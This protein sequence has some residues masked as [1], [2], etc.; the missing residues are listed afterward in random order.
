M[1]KILYLAAVA[2]T[3]ATSACSGKAE[4][5]ESAAVATADTVAAEEEMIA[6]APATLDLS[7][8]K[9]DTTGYTR[10]DSGLL[11]KEVKA[12]KGEKPGAT[13][14]VTVHYTGKHLDGT[15]FDSSVERGE[16]T[17]FPLNRVIPGWTEGVQLMPVGSKYQFIIPSDL[18]YGPQG[19]PGGPIAP[20]EPL[21]FEVELISI[22][23]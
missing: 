19:T 13:D 23:K 22:D 21:Y 5:S 3:V 8:A 20:N 18:A 7:Q 1:K 9:V 16:P 2:L 15:L 12:G 17:S 6:A 11:Y 14:V 4:S 10:T